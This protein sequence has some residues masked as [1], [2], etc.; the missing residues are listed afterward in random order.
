MLSL[1]LGALAR[2]GDSAGSSYCSLEDTDAGRGRP[3]LKLL[4]L[5]TP[6][7]PEYET[8][9]NNGNESGRNGTVRQ[10]T[11]QKP[12]RGAGSIPGGLRQES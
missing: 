1:A 11:R 8:A 3:G 9:G 10:L 6:S 5:L 12:S 2:S 7:R 4:P